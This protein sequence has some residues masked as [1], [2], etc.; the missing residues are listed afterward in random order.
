MT[1]SGLVGPRGIWLLQAGRW[2]PRRPLTVIVSLNVKRRNLSASQP[3]M[4]AEIE[5]LVQSQGGI[6]NQNRKKS[7]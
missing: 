3:A 5:G 2:S 1:R 4:A 6:E 7:I